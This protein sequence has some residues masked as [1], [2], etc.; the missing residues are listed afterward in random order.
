M[1][2]RVVMAPMP[3]GVH[4][5]IPEAVYHADDSA[6]SVSGAK[7]LLPP[8]TPAVF[9]WR[10]EH[11]EDIVSTDAFDFGHA[12]HRTVLGIGPT[13]RYVDAKDWRTKDARN[14]ALAARALGEVPLLRKNEGVLETM[15]ANIRAHPL[16]S[17]LLD[18][19]AGAPEQSLYQVDPE[20]G[21]MLRG[22]LDYLPHTTGRR[23]IVCDLKTAISADPDEFGKA[24]A[25]NGYDMQDAWYRD[26]INLLRLDPDPGFV[27]VVVEKSPPYLVNVVALNAE[28]V[29]IGRIRNRRAIRTYA[30][31]LAADA[32]PG[33]PAEVNAVNL[34]VWY[35]REY[36]E[37]SA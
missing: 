8:S 36:E 23:M 24:A 30:E 6:L 25:N 37:I 19:D 27:F 29:R 31:C 4:P 28:A 14:E 11:P 32:W 20:T 26:L 18:P 34:P 1:A 22:R 12:A 16:A 7:W 10:R 2:D 3:P 21:V 33:Y 17:R 5:G 13:I 9:Q 35:T 15:V